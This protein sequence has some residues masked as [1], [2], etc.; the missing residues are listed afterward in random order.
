LEGEGHV[1]PT[2]AITEEDHIEQRMDVPG[3]TLNSTIVAP[4][5]TSSRQLRSSVVSA[6]EKMS[7]ELRSLQSNHV[8]YLT[9][10]LPD[11]KDQAYQND[12]ALIQAAFHS[13]AGFYDDNNTT[14]TYK[15]VLNRKS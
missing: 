13:V 2:P 10:A 11:T 8:A 12:F 14:N 6:P 5:P 9:K 3:T 15:E 1:G 4:S 7:R